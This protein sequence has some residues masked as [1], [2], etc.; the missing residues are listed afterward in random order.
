M[1]VPENVSIIALSDDLILAHEVE[2]ALSTVDM[3]ATILG[4]EAVR[5]L[6]AQ[7]GVGSYEVI[8]SKMIEAK[9]NIRDS[10]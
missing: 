6:F 8:S 2:P 1:H 7:L 10:C 5:M 9:F 4:Y 3:Q